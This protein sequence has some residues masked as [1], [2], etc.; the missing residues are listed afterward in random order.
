M[1]DSLSIHDCFSRFATIHGTHEASILNTV[2]YN[3]FGHGFFLE[4]GYESYN[5]IMGNFGA[6]VKPGIILPSERSKQVR[7][8]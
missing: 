8:I 2:G 1:I 5:Y 7:S 6:V 3:T 4:D